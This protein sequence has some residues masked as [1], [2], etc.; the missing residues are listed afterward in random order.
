MIKYSAIILAGGRSSRMGQKKASLLYQGKSFIDIIIEKLK[1]V[2]IQ[3]III[4][5]YEYKKDQYIYVE[6]I[7]KNKGPLAGIHA[8]L[9]QSSAQASLVLT[10]DSP[11][12][13]VWFIKQLMEEHSRGSFPAAVTACNG[14]IQPLLG[15][16]EKNL[17]PLCEE[18]LQ[19][20]SSAVKSMLD[21]TGYNIVEY[22]GNEIDIRGCNTPKEYEEV[23][24]F[25]GL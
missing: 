12:V 24:N 25:R 19:S 23:V 9:M 14:R 2:D 17:L 6:D 8:G 20:E 18:T 4:S 3:E 7:F 11:L 16:Y 13:P 5:G 22:P 21:K 1:S 15:I 10:E